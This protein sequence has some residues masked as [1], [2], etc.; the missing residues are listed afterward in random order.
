M[1][2]ATLLMLACCLPQPVTVIVNKTVADRKADPEHWQ[3]MPIPPIPIRTQPPM[4]LPF[5]LS[6]RRP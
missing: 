3:T 6:P 2:P 4:S 1:T 5:G